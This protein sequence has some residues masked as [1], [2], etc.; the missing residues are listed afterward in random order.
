VKSAWAESIASSLEQSLDLLAA[1][2]RECPGELWEAPMWEVAPLD[3]GHTLLGPDWKPITDPEARRVLAGRWIERR[4][5]PWSVAWHALEGLDYDLTAEFAP[6][7]PPPPFANHPHWR[8]LAGLPAAWRTSEILDYVEYCRGRV[9]DTLL[10]MT[11]EQAARPLPPSHRYAGQPHARLIAG[12][13]VHTTE[14]AAQIEG[15]GRW[16]RRGG[17]VKRRP[18]SR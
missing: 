1:A 16:A 12:L 14:H 15:F 10:D 5:T 18:S 8:D 7:K 3:A 2:V 4:A 13:P 17:G 11:D 9:R 6:W